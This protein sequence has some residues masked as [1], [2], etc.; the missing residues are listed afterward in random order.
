MKSRTR[1]HGATAHARS[2]RG[3]VSPD[4]GRLIDNKSG[5]DGEALPFGCAGE[6]GAPVRRGAER[7]AGR[8]APRGSGYRC[9]QP[10]VLQLSVMPTVVQVL[11]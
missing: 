3:I 1:A 8:P 7:L 2:A 11:V 6:A 10:M 5:K 9:V 4:W